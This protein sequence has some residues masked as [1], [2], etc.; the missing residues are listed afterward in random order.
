[1]TGCP[2]EGCVNRSTNID[3]HQRHHRGKRTAAGAPDT[4]LVKRASVLLVLTVMR[5]GTNEEEP[6][7]SGGAVDHGSPAAATA[8]EMKTEGG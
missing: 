2:C 7:A 8:E 1:M 5:L 3:C 6:H 4:T